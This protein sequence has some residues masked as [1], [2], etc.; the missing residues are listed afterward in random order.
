M[1]RDP[2]TEVVSVRLT[3]AERVRLDEMGGPSAALRRLLEPVH[4]CQPNIVMT[5]PGPLQGA[6]LV[7]DDMTVGGTWPAVN[8]R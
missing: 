6:S 1:N 2:R 4:I 5:G 8:S 7:W 3:K